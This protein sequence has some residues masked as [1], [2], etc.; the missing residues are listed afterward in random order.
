MLTIILRFR[1]AHGVKYLLKWF[2]TLENAEDMLKRL[3]MLWVPLSLFY[4]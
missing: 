2:N 1:D 3:I 4:S